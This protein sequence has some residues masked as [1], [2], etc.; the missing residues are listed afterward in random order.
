MSLDYLKL[1]RHSPGF[2]LSAAL[3]SLAFI[4]YRLYQSSN[5]NAIAP[6]QWDIMENASFLNGLPDPVCFITDLNFVKESKFFLCFQPPSVICI[7]KFIPNWA[8][9]WYFGKYLFFVTLPITHKTTRTRVTG[10]WQCLDSCLNTWPSPWR[11]TLHW[12]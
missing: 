8:Y 7:S 6:K 4:L 9:S 11:C 10:P 5:S 12:K 2:H 1:S 3:F